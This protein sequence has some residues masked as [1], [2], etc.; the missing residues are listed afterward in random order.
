MDKEIYR[1]CSKKGRITNYRNGWQNKRWKT[2][3]VAEQFCMF[4]KEIKKGDLVIVYS[5]KRVYGI[6]KIIGN[7]YFDEEKC[8]HLRKVRW[9]TTSQLRYESLSP[10]AQ[11]FLSK[12]NTISKVEGKIAKEIL[13]KYSINF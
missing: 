4:Y 1:I 11:A 13:D 6:A 5:N 3:Y 2:S 7:A 10:Q 8:A 12:R 9:L